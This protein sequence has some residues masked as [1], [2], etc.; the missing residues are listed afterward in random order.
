[1]RYVFG[2]CF[3][4]VSHKILVLRV[5]PLPVFFLKVIRSILIYVLMFFGVM[6]FIN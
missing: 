1:M 3:I 2:N 4:N 6:V 5:L